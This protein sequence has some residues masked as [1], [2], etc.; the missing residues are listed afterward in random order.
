MP[1]GARLHGRR[2]HRRTPSL[3]RFA[4]HPEGVRGRPGIL[5]LR[6]L[7]IPGARNEGYHAAEEE[8]RSGIGEDETG[9]QDYQDLQ[10]W[11]LNGEVY[12]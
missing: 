9:L 5:R 1:G 3:P 6:P 2:G 10:D 4:R 11:L 12:G 7:E 8:L